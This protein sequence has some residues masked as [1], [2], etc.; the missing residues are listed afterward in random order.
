MHECDV[1]LRK[2][3]NF[4]TV[5]TLQVNYGITVYKGFWIYQGN[6]P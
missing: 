3:I 1:F 5:L 4:A 2:M 6:K